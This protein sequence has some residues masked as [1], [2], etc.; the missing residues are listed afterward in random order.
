MASSSHSFFYPYPLNLNV[1]N[2]VSLK[3]THNNFL[4][5]KT[6]ILALIESQDM[7]GFLTGSIAAPPSHIV[8]PAD[9]QQLASNPKFE[10]WR[11][12]DRLIKGWITGTLSKTVLGLVV[13]LNSSQEIWS[14]LID[15]FAQESQERGFHLTHMLTTCKKGNDALE[16]YVVKFKAICDDLA[17]IGKSVGDK[18]KAFWLLQGL[19]KGYEP[20][21]MAMLKPPVPSYKE[22]ISLLQSL[23]V[24]S[25]FL[26]SEISPQVAFY[27]QRDNQ[28]RSRG[29]YQMSRGRG[30]YNR[31]GRGGGFHQ[32]YPS[33]RG[34]Y[35]SPQTD[36]N[37]KP[38]PQPKVD[39]SNTSFNSSKDLVCQICNKKNHSA[40]RCYNRFNHSFQADDATHAL[41]A[42]TITDPQD[43]GW[44]VDTGATAHM[45]GDAGKL[46]NISP[47]YGSDIVIV[48]NG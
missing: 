41:A 21:V 30:R 39:G 22:L 31:G 25:K 17:A 44:L 14:T 26:N 35:N 36:Y 38:Q 9:P 1:A 40:M 46:K 47:Y 7:E 18:E 32:H 10:S 8:D 3:L 48:G 42:L 19:G 43:S 16:V 23:E 27:A 33:H 24:R 37:T 28:N 13:G 5:W 20:F 11:R 12:S 2:F 45:T 34:G 6:Q 4:L 29:T 15:A